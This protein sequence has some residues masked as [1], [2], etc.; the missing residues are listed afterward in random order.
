M[1]RTRSLNL[2][3]FLQALNKGV[4]TYL[5]KRYHDGWR[6][7]DEEYRTKH[8][9]VL[10]AAKNFKEAS[11]AQFAHMVVGQASEG[12]EAWDD[13]QTVKAQKFNDFMGFMFF[14]D[15]ALLTIWNLVMKTISEGRLV[16]EWQ[17]GTTERSSKNAIFFVSYFCPFCLFHLIKERNV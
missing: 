16:K 10:E 8:P 11:M 14:A 17:K 1:L 2:P 9:T 15:D 5:Y 6:V 12:K 3:F 4:R 7:V 13:E